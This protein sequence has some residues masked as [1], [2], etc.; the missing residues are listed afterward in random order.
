MPLP[1]GARL[2][3]YEIINAIGAGGSARGSASERSETSR[4]AWGWVPTQ[5]KEEGIRAH[6]GV[7]RWR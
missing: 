7:F 2:G 6:S 3:P 1:A 5:L 4:A